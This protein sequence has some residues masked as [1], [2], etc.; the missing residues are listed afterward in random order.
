MAGKVGTAL[1]KSFRCPETGLTRHQLVF[2]KGVADGLSYNAAYKAAYKTDNVRPDE[3]QRRA[4]EL[5]REEKVAAELG[6]IRAL[7]REKCAYSVEDAVAEAELARQLAMEERQASAATGAVA[8]KAKLL[9]LMTD[10]VETTN[11]TAPPSLPDLE[12]QLREVM[13]Q[14][15]IAAPDDL[16][17]TAKDNVVPL[18]K[19]A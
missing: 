6:R 2:V 14:L 19:R 12:K 1:G 15:G 4:W 3:V 17:E 7:A 11:K 18:S 8:L 13:A 10:K 9:G 5:S 16:A